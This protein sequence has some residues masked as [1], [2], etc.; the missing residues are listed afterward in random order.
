MGGPLG[1]VSGPGV[2]TMVIVGCGGMYGCA[3]AYPVM[4]GG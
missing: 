1:G 2:F 4:T 3:G